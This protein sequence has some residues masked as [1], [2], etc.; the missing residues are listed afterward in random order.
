MITPEATPPHVTA[1]LKK[2][3]PV[4]LWGRNGQ[5]HLQGQLQGLLQGQLKCQLQ[6]HLQGQLQGQLSRESQSST[7]KCIEQKKTVTTFT[8]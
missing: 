7:G 3:G 6:G 1:Y 8:L 5:G 4:Y 2:V